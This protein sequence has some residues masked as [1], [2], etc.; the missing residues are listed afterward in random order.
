MLELIR[1]TNSEQEDRSSDREK[2]LVAGVQGGPGP[3]ICIPCPTCIPSMR[4]P[5][6]L[7]S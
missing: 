7:A 1:V 2:G 3:A 5:T 6:P 4:Y